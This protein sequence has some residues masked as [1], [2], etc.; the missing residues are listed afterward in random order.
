[1]SHHNKNKPNQ[2]KT[3]SPKKNKFERFFKEGLLLRSDFFEV[4]FLS[5]TSSVEKN[6]HVMVRKKVSKKATERNKWRRRIK[7]IIRK[8]KHNDLLLLFNIRSGKEKTS[9]SKELLEA[10]LKIFEQY[11]KIKKLS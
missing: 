6:V 8:E 3:S 2:K 1:M 11:K 5:V 4:W 7:E 9:S 10:W